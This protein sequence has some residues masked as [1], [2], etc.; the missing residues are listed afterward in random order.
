MHSNL[1]TTPDFSTDEFPNVLIVDA[2]PN[3]IEDIAYWCRT[4][5][6]SLNVYI[7][8]TDMNDETWLERAESIVTHILIN[9]DA[10][11]MYK[12]LLLKDS[13]ASYWGNKTMI[14]ND[15]EVVGPLDFFIG[16]YGGN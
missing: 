14:G 10:P 3:E 1:I 6:M 4:A 7:Y 15:R 12:N 8:N 11:A 9:V 2:S 13:R 5:P 16:T